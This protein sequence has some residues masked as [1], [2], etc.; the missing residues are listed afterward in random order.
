MASDNSTVNRTVTFADPPTSTNYVSVSVPIAKLNSEIM[1]V[2]F[3]KAT[4]PKAYPGGLEAMMKDHRF[5]DS[6]PLGKH[7]SYKYLVDF[8]GMSYSGRFMAF[9][10]SDSVAV[11]STVYEEFFSDWIQPWYV[12]P[13]RSPFPFCQ[14]HDISNRVH[15]IPLSTMYKEIYNV[16]AFFSGATETVL[17]AANSTVL[18][19]PVKDRQLG[20]GDVRLR[21]IARAGKEWK[22]TIGRTLDM[23]GPLSSS[24]L[25]AILFA[26]IRL[27]YVYRLCLEY[28]R[29]SADD[30]DSMNF[31]L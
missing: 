19:T 2:A 31:S 10:A 4:N 15:F 8:D 27:A 1:D 18:R 24:L 26:D 6:V 5:G 30:R 29:L 16:H 22:K 21:R 28:A 20:V 12:R 23:E 11:K 25:A 9:L 7:W 14:T 13:L 17:E 3:V